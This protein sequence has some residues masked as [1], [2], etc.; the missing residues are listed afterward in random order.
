MSEFSFLCVEGFDV[1]GSMERPWFSSLDTKETLIDPYA[2]EVDP[3]MF[4]NEE[5]GSPLKERQDF[6]DS[7]PIDSKEHR[8][9]VDRNDVEN[10]MT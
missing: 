2:G 9:D 5:V 8:L 4:H 10:V 6:L 1:E 7:I 3:L